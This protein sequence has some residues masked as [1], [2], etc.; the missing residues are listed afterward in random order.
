M[1]STDIKEQI[2]ETEEI[3]KEANDLKHVEIL[4]GVGIEYLDIPQSNTL[5]TQTPD[6]A[7]RED[8]K[9]I[10]D[11]TNFEMD[12]FTNSFKE[13]TLQE[14]W[15]ENAKLN[16]F[17]D[18]EMA[19]GYDSDEQEAKSDSCAYLNVVYTFSG[20]NAIIDTFGKLRKLQRDKLA[21]FK[22]EKQFSLTVE[23]FFQSDNDIFL[24][25][26]ISST[27][28]QHLLLVKGII[29]KHIRTHRIDL[30]QQGK[31]ICIVVHL[32]RNDSYDIPLTFLS[33][34]RLLF[35]DSIRKPGTLLE[36]F[37]SVDIVQIFGERKPSDNY[38]KNMMLW[39]FSRIQFTS[40]HVSVQ[41]IED[42]MTRMKS[43]SEVITTIEAYI[44]S[45][46][47]LQNVASSSSCLI[48][49]KNPYELLK[50]GSF[51]DALEHGIQE[52]I[53]HPLTL[54]IFKLMQKNLLNPIFVEDSRI[55]T[56]ARKLVWKQMVLSE[57]NI[58]TD[59]I[60][61]PSGPECYVCS[62]DP[63]NFYMPC[64]QVLMMQIDSRKNDY[65]EIIE[66]LRIDN[67]IDPDEEMPKDLFEQATTSCIDF[68]CYEAI[69]I[70]EE[71]FTY[72][73][74]NKDF[75]RDFCNFH[76]FTMLSETNELQRI[77]FSNGHY[78]IL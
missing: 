72:T 21:I 57:N 77:T 17:T 71:E 31:Y 24:L 40:K 75:I 11:V 13:Q 27:E 53:R 38:I 22:S 36:Q 69:N 52:I 59:D 63:L 58:S 74:R 37:F 29:E 3:L 65:L 7:I 33:G 50:A 51:I 32:E 41:T 14:V 5:D 12:D 42:L 60:P 8:T 26:C 61:P 62:S 35:I 56:P 25:H 78:R 46:Y 30:C 76:S 54:F 23:E 9:L 15:E 10:E 66:R 2:A 20:I 28:S 48:V 43:S 73:D 64:S 39:A 45:S 6:N 47:E 67:S 4:D 18:K 19:S 1:A 70:L 55:S 49:A 68:I 44:L 34:W 16:D